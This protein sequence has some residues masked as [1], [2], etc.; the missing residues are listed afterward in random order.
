MSSTHPNPLFSRAEIGILPC[1]KCGTPMR[2]ACIE[3]TGPGLDVRTF[4][5][6]KCNTI[7]RFAVA[8]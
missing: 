2:L 6:T 4:E 5:C 3:P 8:I 7:Q 1:S